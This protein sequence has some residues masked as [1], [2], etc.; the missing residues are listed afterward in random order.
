[1]RAGRK[2][3]MERQGKDKARM[4]EKKDEGH[5]PAGWL[6]QRMRG[7]VMRERGTAGGV[8]DLDR[9]KRDIEKQCKC[10]VIL[11]HF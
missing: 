9:V 10:K 8:Y 5:L 3:E 6:R 4:R 1:M 2:K 11:S 7:R